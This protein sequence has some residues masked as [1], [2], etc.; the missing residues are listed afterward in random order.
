MLGLSKA[1]L[2]GD[3]VPNK[4]NMDRGCLGRMFLFLRGF[5]SKSKQWGGPLFWFVF[6]FTNNK[7]I[8]RMF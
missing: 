8:Y 5:G 7:L 6:P 1:C 4:S 3:D 2:E